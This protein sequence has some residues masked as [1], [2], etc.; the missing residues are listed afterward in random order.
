MRIPSRLRPIPFL[1]VLGLAACGGNDDPTAPT[2]RHPE[3]FLPTGLSGWTLSGDAQAGTTEAE[4]YSIIDGGAE[5]Y[6]GHGL[7][8]FAT[9]TYTGTGTQAGGTLTVWIYELDSAAH[10]QALYEDSEIVPPSPVPELGL[11]DRARMSS[12]FP[13]KELEFTRDAYY[14]DLNVSGLSPDQA[15]S[16]LRL[17]GTGIDQKITS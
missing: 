1:L 15:E 17:V 4:L 16:Q 5:I 10:A 6:A 9:A 12:T 14:I 2:I 8:E 11:G 3:D 7:E 13:G